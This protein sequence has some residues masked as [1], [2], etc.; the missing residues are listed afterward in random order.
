LPDWA[1][2]IERFKFDGDFS[3]SLSFYGA[4]CSTMLRK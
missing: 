1:P 2:V 4:G 3:A